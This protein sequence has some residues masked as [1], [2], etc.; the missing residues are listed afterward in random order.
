MSGPSQEPWQVV[1][2]RI[3][4]VLGGKKYDPEQ[5]ISG[6][7][8]GEDKSHGRR[9]LASLDGFMLEDCLSPAF[10][11]WG[12]NWRTDRRFDRFVETKIVPRLSK[13]HKMKPKVLVQL[14]R[15]LAAD[16]RSLGFVADS[17]EAPT[18]RLWL[19]AW[20]LVDQAQQRGT[21]DADNYYGRWKDGV[22]SEFV[23]S[24]GD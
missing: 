10:D 16:W 1:G 9:V 14:M 2:R 21:W 22:A 3:F 23:P 20:L 13:Q 17:K 18:E 6:T 4:D 11:V 7:G 8:L 15:L 5:P 12:L 19:V 24:R